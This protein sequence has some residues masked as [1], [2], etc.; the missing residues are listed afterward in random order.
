MTYRLLIASLITGGV[1]LASNAE[2]LEP[3]KFGDFENWV[4][5]DITES[6]VIGGKHKTIYEVGPT[7]NISKNIPYKNLGGSP[8]ATSN[9]YA[10]VSGV[11]KGSNAVY[12]SNR[13]ATNKCAKLCTQM[14]DVKVLGLINMHVMVAG[15][16]FLGE[17]IEPVSSTSDPYKKME[18][19]MSYTKR[20][21]FLSLDY[22]VDMPDTDIR[23]K[24]TGFGPKKTLRGR[25]AAVVF[26]IL[27]K[28]WED[29]DGN[30]HASRIATGGEHFKNGTQWISGHKIPLLY[31]DV[32]KNPQYNWLGLRNGDNAYYARNSKGK[33]VKVNEESWDTSNSAPTHAIV[34]I[35]SGNG[36]PFI[37]TEGLT[38][39]VDNIA[40]G[41]N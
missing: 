27:Q 36:E 6:V 1:S 14:E 11:T 5:R 16:M 22:K 28:R 21:S 25:D 34:M 41:F 38:F 8:W 23:T 2:K 18:M 32:S 17:M 33:L 35:S 12:P 15:S 37:G 29:A 39:Y 9:V 20:P 7:Q 3:I 24:S 4:S 13:T 31:G 26:I 30:I 19:G 10:K 40:F